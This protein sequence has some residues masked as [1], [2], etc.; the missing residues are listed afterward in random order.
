MQ[1]Q[2][3]FPPKFSMFHI[4]AELK[5]EQAATEWK[6]E[7]DIT[8]ELNRLARQRGQ[9]VDVYMEEQRRIA[10]YD[11]QN[12]VHESKQT[13]QKMPELVERLL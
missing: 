1:Q 9:S 3:N 6:E 12:T 13:V 11:S 2:N 8:L 7:S 4:I 5:D 10:L